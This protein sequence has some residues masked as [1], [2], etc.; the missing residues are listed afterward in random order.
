MLRNL[1]SSSYQPFDYETK[2]GVLDSCQTTFFSWSLLLT[3]EKKTVFAPAA[4]WARESCGF[5]DG[6]SL[7]RGW[8]SSWIG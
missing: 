3:A 1:A 5:E 2:M 4:V 6:A 7:S 8:V